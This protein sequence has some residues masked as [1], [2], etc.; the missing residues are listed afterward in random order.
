MSKF[1][2][3]LLLIAFVSFSVLSKSCES[4]NNDTDINKTGCFALSGQGKY[5]D[6]CCFYEQIYPHN[7]VNKSLCITVPYSSVTSNKQEYFDGT[8]YNVT[9]NNSS[10]TSNS[11]DTARKATVLEQCGNAHDSK[12]SLKKCK[13]YSSFVDSC[14]YYSGKNDEDDPIKE[15]DED[16]KLEKGC[17]WLGSK[18]KGKIFWASAKLECSVSYLKYTFFN[19][20]SFAVLLIIFG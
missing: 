14:C 8:L 11:S 15:P 7:P 12:L 3:Q 5:S 4:I 10:N 17:Y 16:V 9:C 2:F 18:Y 20:I 13:K 1:L 6:L 19:L